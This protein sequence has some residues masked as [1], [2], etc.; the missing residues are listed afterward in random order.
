VTA[1]H[2]DLCIEQGADWPGLA[3][4]ILDEE[5]QPY[6]LTGCSAKGQIRRRKDTDAVLFAW[7]S[8][9]G[10]DEGL[11]TLADSTL[12]IRVLA[13][14]SDEWDWRSGVYDIE[15]T[16]PSAPVGKQVWRIAQGN[17]IIDQE[18]TE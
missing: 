18:V 14:E 3:F 4:P 15:L 16:N 1:V 11:I 17:V 7:S 13:S 12:T 8:D 5:G 10:E 9:P 2:V 6:D